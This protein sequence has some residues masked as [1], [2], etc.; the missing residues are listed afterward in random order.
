MYA[1]SAFLNY[2]R[3]EIINKRIEPDCIPIY[4]FGPCIGSRENG[5][6]TIGRQIQ[7]ICNTSPLE[8]TED[9]TDSLP[10]S[11]NINDIENKI[12]FDTVKTC[13]DCTNV[14]EGNS[15]YFVCQNEFSVF[16]PNALQS[17]A[18]LKTG[19]DT[20]SL[21][22]IILS[23]YI[24]EKT[25]PPIVSDGSLL[26]TF[27][28]GSVCV[29]AVKDDICK[30]YCAPGFYSPTNYFDTTCTFDI[31]SK[32]YYWNNNVQCLCQKDCGGL[33]GTCTSLFK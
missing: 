31:I 10:Y 24:P 28:D 29:G 12:D 16:A 22:N 26:T 21:N 20:K 14:S 3:T 13:G 7:P 30:T 5:A 33:G 1:G 32:T 19:F 18:C 4:V 27:F 9:C 6:T 2:S 23:C 25:C 8:I 15:C 11:C 17:I